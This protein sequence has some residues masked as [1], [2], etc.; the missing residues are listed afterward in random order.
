MAML[1]GLRAPPSP[2]GAAGVAGIAFL[3]PVTRTG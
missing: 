1:A 2:E 3:V